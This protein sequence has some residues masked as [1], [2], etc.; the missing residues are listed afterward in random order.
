MNITKTN[1][2]VF[3]LTE[4]LQGI[5]LISDEVKLLRTI[6]NM[7]DM[8]KHIENLDHQPEKVKSIRTDISELQ[9]RLDKLKANKSNA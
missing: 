6:E 9:D 2:A 3:K 1:N 8:I 4:N 7:T 5:D